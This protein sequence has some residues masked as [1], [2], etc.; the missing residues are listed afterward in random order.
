MEK[1]IE[2][3]K[4]QGIVKV[5]DKIEAPSSDFGQ[6]TADALKVSVDAL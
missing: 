4:K 3:G 6:G 1:E 5:Q 2:A